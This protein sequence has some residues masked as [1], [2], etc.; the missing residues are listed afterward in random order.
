M[1]VVVNSKKAQDDLDVVR[2][3]NSAGR[4]KPQKSLQKSSDEVI[5]YND[6]EKHADACHDEILSEMFKTSFSTSSPTFGL[7]SLHEEKMTNSA[8]K[9]EQTSQKQQHFQKSEIDKIW[10]R[11]LMPPPPPRPRRLRPLLTKK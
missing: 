11:I 8:S 1:E 6:E 5:I 4:A 3:H 7:N 9:V 10:D 2:F